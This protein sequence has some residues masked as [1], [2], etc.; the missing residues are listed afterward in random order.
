MCTWLTHEA[1]LGHE[2][3]LESRLCV[4]SYT[5]YS[6]LREGFLSLLTKQRIENGAFASGHMAVCQPCA[7][8]NI[9][10]HGFCL[11]LWLTTI[12]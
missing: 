5:F 9:H 12:A 10:A 11:C 6:P 4:H 2:L 8:P 3:L 7:L 1:A